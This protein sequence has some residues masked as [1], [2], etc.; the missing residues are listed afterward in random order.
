MASDVERN[1]FGM[2]WDEMFEMKSDEVF[3]M[4][5]E[6]AFERTCL[7]EMKCK[8]LQRKDREQERIRG[9][10]WEKKKG[11]EQN[12]PDQMNV[13]NDENDVPAKNRNEETSAKIR[14]YISDVNKTS[15]VFGFNNAKG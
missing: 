14:S 7:F 12:S 15:N 3:E 13:E 8:D 9:R 11:C 1:V 5:P 4:K 10:D 6:E 2:K